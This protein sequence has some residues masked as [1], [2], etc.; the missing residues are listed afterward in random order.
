MH[1][2]SHCSHSF[3]VVVYDQ[4][5]QGHFQFRTWLEFCSFVGFSELSAVEYKWW[6]LGW[7]PIRSLLFTDTL[8]NL[9]FLMSLQHFG[10]FFYHLQYLIPIWSHNPLFTISKLKRHYYPT[11]EKYEM[12]EKWASVNSSVA[13]ISFTEEN[14][15]VHNAGILFNAGI[16]SS[17]NGGNSPTENHKVSESLKDGLAMCLWE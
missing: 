17:C 16:L 5:K 14:V 2:K 13:K 3:K 4:R 6:R 1:I 7:Y 12:Y 8:H 11:G 9:Y 15:S 10:L